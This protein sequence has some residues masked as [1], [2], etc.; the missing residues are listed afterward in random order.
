MLKKGTILDLAAGRGRVD[1]V[2][3]EGVQQHRERALRD[4][5]H[6]VLRRVDRHAD[7]VAG[8]ARHVV[9]DHVAQHVGDVA[10]PRELVERAGPEPRQREP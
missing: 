5:V 6:H 3:Q 10:V 2:I 1:R 8:R 4:D 9:V 7:V